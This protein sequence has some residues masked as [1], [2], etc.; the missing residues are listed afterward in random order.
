MQIFLL[1]RRDSQ[2]GWLGATETKHCIKVL[3][4]QNGDDIFCIDGQGAAYQAKILNATKEE[5]HLQLLDTYPNW[6][7]HAGN[8]RLA[9]SPLRLKDRFEFLIEKAVELGVNEIF[10][11]TCKRTDKYQAKFKAAR[12]ETQITAATKQ[13]K[14][15]QIATLHPLQA[16]EDFLA[17]TPAGQ[18]FIAYCE[19]QP[20]PL[21][22]QV[23]TIQS[24]DTLTLLIGPE[25]DFTEEEVRCAE[26]KNYLAV[27]LG[28][29]RLRTET[30]AIY[31]LGIF[32]MLRGY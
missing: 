25:G 29:N 23:E 28:E 21:H 9:V 32:K 20:V 19:E 17:T 13:C 5:T 15:S 18:H 14:R 1:E 30:A 24:A 8:I 12:L 2:F 10:P 6:G 22:Q 7:E 31:G 27:S 11:I 16:I 4:H 3:R 26:R